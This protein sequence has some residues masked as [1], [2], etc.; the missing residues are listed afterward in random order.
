VLF[1][2]RAPHHESVLWSGGIAPCILD[3]DTRWRSVV[4]F[5]I[6]PLYPQGKSPWY[7]LIGGWVDPRAGL[8]AVVRIKIPSPYRD[9]NPPIIQSVAQRYTAELPRLLL[10]KL[11]MRN[12]MNGLHADVIGRLTCLFRIWGVPCS[13]LGAKWL[14][15]HSWFFLVPPRDYKGFTLK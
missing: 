13:S 14:F 10:N 1:F 7:P 12:C 15:W 5:T 2:N 6:R 3:F 11:R 9:S 4:S 8:D